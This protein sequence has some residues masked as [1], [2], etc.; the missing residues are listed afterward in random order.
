MWYAQ[1][2]VWEWSGNGLRMVRE[3]YS[4][5]TI[6]GHSPSIRVPS[7]YHAQAMSRLVILRK[8]KVMAF[9]PSLYYKLR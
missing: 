3:W 6:L 9:I 5:S 1:R 8:K 4:L 7:R 2:S